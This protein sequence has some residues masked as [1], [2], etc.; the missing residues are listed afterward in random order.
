MIVLFYEIDWIR[1]RFSSTAQR[2][3]ARAP[4][5][6]RNYHIVLCHIISYYIIWY[7]IVLCHRRVLVHII[8]YVSV[9]LN[10]I[11]L[12]H[13]SVIYHI[14]YVGIILHDVTM[15]KLD[16]YYY[17]IILHVMYY[18]ILYDMIWYYIILCVNR[19]ESIPPVS[20]RQVW[21]TLFYAH[22]LFSMN[23]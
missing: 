4:P 3:V 10:H 6:E 21:Y 12:Y 11:I 7:D 19:W 20:S 18:I 5:G 16:R 15:R 14:I 8:I 23:K 2:S 13:R 22:I 1:H 9:L 17:S